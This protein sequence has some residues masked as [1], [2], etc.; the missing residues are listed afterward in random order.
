[1]ARSWL[2][3]LTT[4]ALLLAQG[5]LLLHLLLVPHRTCEHGELVELA[6]AR[7]PAP[8]AQ[9]PRSDHPQVDL[10]RA[11]CGSHEHCDA[12]ALRHRLPEVEPSVGP[13]TL[14]RI[15]PIATA[16]ARAERRP[17]ALL[18]LAPKSSPPVC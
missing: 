12:L 3:L 18:S 8:A 16:G 7:I 2:A 4:L 6:R 15:D 1:V 5:P 17:V 14:L 9:V 10:D 11:G 13:A